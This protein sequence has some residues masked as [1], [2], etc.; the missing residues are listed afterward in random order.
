[1][2][3]GK[4]ASSTPVAPL[5]A[6]RFWG[7]VG[8]PRGILRAMLNTVLWW[9]GVVFA[10]DLLWT[11][12]VWAPFLRPLRRRHLCPTCGQWVSEGARR[13]IVFRR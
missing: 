6:R 5:H 7:I 8:R 2:F 4:Q 3:H 13:L 10:I 11:L 9:L 1:M 12:V